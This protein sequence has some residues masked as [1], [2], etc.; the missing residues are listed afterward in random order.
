M[1]NLQP[2]AFIS[3]SWDDSSVMYWGKHFAD[4]LRANG[5]EVFLDAHEMDLGDRIES[6][7][8][9]A[10]KRADYF[11]V[12]LTPSYK[13]KMARRENWV[14]HEYRLFNGYT[15]F[16]KQKIKLLPILRSGTERSSIPYE[17]SSLSWIDMRSNQDYSVRFKE[18]ISSVLT[19]LKVSKTV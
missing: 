17:M 4:D 11:F 10:I 14:E 2:K 9:Y 12:I 8:A 18:V 6:K 7:V 13:Q 5:I 16:Q 19:D 1:N 15:E 3:Y